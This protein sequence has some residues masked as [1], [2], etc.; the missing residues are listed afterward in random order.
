M[1]GSDLLPGGH[2]VR[3]ISTPGPLIDGLLI[4]VTD[5]DLVAAVA[6]NLE[7][8]INDV[9]DVTLG[10]LQGGELF[11][12]SNNPAVVRGLIEKLD[13]EHGRVAVARWARGEAGSSTSLHSQ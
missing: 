13:L 6:F 10:L 9:L 7:V 1:Q 11:S 3:V 5:L 8:E 4:A 12:V 2:S